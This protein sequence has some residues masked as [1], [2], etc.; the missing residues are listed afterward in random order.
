MGDGKATPRVWTIVT[1]VSALLLCTGTI[2]GAVLNGPI[3]EKL[4]G[5]DAVAAVPNENP[6]VQPSQAQV[7]ERSN[8]AIEEAGPMDITSVDIDE[9]LGSGN[10]FCLDGYPNGVKIRDM[11][12][13]FVVGYPFFQI[14]SPNGEFTIGQSV[15]SGGPATGWLQDDLLDSGCLT[16]IDRLPLTPEEVDAELGANNWHCV[17]GPSNGFNVINVPNNFVV[18]YP[19]ISV[20]KNDV[21]YSPDEAVPSGGRATVW[22][23]RDLPRDQ[24]P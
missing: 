18:Q 17:N 12:S 14:D 2:L 1:I 22:F 7:D 13:N 24:C 8:T 23:S 3:I 6:S 21:V 10:W 19:L 5:D 4:L 11:P 9:A 20:E 15:P 16:D